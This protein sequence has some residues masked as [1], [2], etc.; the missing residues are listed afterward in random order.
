MIEEHPESYLFEA[1]TLLPVVEATDPGLVPEVLWRLVASRL[2]YGNPRAI[3]SETSPVQIAEVAYY[4]RELAAA[5]LEPI[6][7]RMEH[8]NP[9][10]LAHWNYEFVA[11]SLI[12]PHAAFAR[13]EKIPV[14]QDTDINYG[15]NAARIALGASLA[16]SR[17]ERWRAKHDDREI[18]FGSK[19]NL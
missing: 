7:A 10:D 9:D 12:D 19:R 13:L 2:P 11:W 16:R 1:S 18:I 5:L 17:L 6:L 14:A 4:D 3:R 15:K 8:T